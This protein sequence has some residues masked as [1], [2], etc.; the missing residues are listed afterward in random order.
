MRGMNKMNRMDPEERKAMMDKWRS[1]SEFIDE[2]HK[3]HEEVVRA[4]LERSGEGVDAKK[5]TNILAN[6][7]LNN[8]DLQREGNLPI[9]EITAAQETLTARRK[10][11][12]DD[13]YKD[14]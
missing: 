5:V 13:F 11:K 2:F 4:T 9:A 6:R 10:R 7:H 8:P 3:K 1:D 14:K 12:E